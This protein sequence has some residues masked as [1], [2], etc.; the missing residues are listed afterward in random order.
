MKSPA[1]YLIPDLICRS[2]YEIPFSHFW[3]EGIRFLVF[4][5]D[6]TLVS[7]D[8]P[9]P[10]ERLKNFLFSLKEKGFD[11]AFVS[12]NT[13]QR[14]ETFNDAFGFLSFPD[15]HK[16]LKRALRPLI[17]KGIAPQEILVV[18]DQLL[19]DVLA[20]RLWGLRAVTVPPVQERENRFFRF[21]R[22][23]ERPFVRAYYRRKE[24]GSVKK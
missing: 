18:G 14:V 10:D 4:D 16:P 5:I 17:Q 20:A 7:Y 21:K 9:R 8:T 19:T 2:V 12:N 11:I 3:E 6:N 22:K 13:A 23:L 1:D 15:A 24:K